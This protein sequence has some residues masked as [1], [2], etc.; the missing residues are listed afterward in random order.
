VDG[1]K[2]GQTTMAELVKFVLATAK[3]KSLDQYAEPQFAG[4]YNENEVFL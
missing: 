3:E 2:D 1:Q 4:E